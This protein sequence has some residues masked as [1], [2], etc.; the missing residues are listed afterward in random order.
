MPV[1]DY[2][3]QLLGFLVRDRGISHEAWLAFAS[4]SPWLRKQPPIEGVNP[5]T[6]LPNHFSYSN[7]VVVDGA[8]SVG[9]LAWEE[10]ECVGVAGE[11]VALRT[12]IVSLCETFDAQFE[13][14]RR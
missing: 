6:R 3:R 1:I 11:E 9:L 8:E 10:A 5:F 14:I 4:S 13:P 12:V 2:N 7:F